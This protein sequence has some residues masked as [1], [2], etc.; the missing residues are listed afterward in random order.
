MLVCLLFLCSFVY[1]VDFSVLNR[2]GTMKI[3]C[4]QRYFQLARI[5]LYIYKLN[6]LGMLVL[7]NY[8][9]FSVRK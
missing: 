8:G 6:T 1:M 3:G 4:S 5:S 7:Y 2:L 9:A